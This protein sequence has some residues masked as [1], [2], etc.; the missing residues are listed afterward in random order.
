MTTAYHPQTDGQT[1][2]VNQTLEQFLRC[3]I[4]Y[5][6][7]DWSEL[8]S[9]AEFAYNNA[10]HESTK[11]SPFFIEYGRHPRAGPTLVKEVSRTDM[12]DIM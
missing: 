7:D 12:D 2:R 9:S 4:D 11:H 3:Y 1:E 6:N 8:L 5:Q 10:A